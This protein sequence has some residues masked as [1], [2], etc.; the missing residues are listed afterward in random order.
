MNGTL[1]KEKITEFIGVE[2]Y[3]YVEF[4]VDTFYFNTDN[5]QKWTWKNRQQ[6]LYKLMNVDSALE[7]LKNDE[8]ICTYKRTP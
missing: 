1:Y 8:K 4:L 2:K 6:V 5:A 3:E 7:S